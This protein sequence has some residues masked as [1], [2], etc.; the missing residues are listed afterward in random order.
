MTHEDLGKAFAMLQDSIQSSEF[1]MIA[2]YQTDKE[3]GSMIPKAEQGEMTDDYIRRIASMI[4]KAAS[5]D[6]DFDSNILRSAV[7]TAGVNLAMMDDLSAMMAYEMLSKHIEEIKNKGEN[8][9]SDGTSQQR[10]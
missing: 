2:I 4:G 1:D 10:R 3:F 5:V 8:S 9:R 7:M 6:D